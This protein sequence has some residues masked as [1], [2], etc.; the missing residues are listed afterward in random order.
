MDDEPL[1]VGP[2]CGLTDSGLGVEKCETTGPSGPTRIRRRAHAPRDDE[3][4]RF[5]RAS[6]GLSLFAAFRKN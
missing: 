1:R 2:A 5:G 3:V 6:L 4:A